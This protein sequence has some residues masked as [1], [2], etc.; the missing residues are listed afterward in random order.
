MR[1]PSQEPGLLDLPRLTDHATT[2]GVRDLDRASG[3]HQREQGAGETP[4]ASGLG[5]GAVESADLVSSSWCS[6]R[7]AVCAELSEL[8]AINIA[9]Y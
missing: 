1:A 7:R 8:H 3:A 6:G 9:H 2:A 5:A 4:K